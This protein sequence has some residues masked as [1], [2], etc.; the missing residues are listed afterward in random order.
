MKIRSECMPCLFD[1][2]KFECDLAF[3]DDEAGKLEALMEVARF[4]ARNI[5]RETV[6]A[7]IGTERGRIISR[8]SGVK[9]PYAGLKAVSNR[10]GEAI[11][12]E[13]KQY[14][15]RAGDGLF[16][17]LKIAAAANSMEYGVR[18][19][20]FD[21]DHFRSEFAAI[22]GEEVS[23]NLERVKELLGR[24]DRVLYI[25]DNAGEVIIDRFVVEELEGMG[26][27]VIVSPKSE[28]VINDVTAE[29]LRDLGF[30]M[31]RVVPSGS[32]VGVSLDEAPQDFKDLLFDPEVLVIA[33][34]MGN[35]ETLSEFEDR[36]K[37]RLIYVFRAKC[38]SVADSA[39][40]ERGTLVIKAV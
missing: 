5:D 13:A 22:L 25:L 12:P 39:G 28:P 8:L 27:E 16:A 6:P 9:D 32:F 36:L 19:H 18:G 31:E 30:D 26:K 24:F 21:H 38:L 20:E 3:G 15:Q 10:A 2:A 35:Y 11:L 37:G 34:G 29:E 17:L 23:G 4:A 7:F 1:R 33:K 40:V 14:Y